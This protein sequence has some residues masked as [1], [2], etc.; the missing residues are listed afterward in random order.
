MNPFQS[1]LHLLSDPNITFILF[2]IGFYGLLFEV[3]HPNF[4]T[5]ILGGL[6]LILG[7]IGFGLAAV[8]RGRRVALLGLA[9]RPVLPGSERR[10]ATDCSRSAG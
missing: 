9:M 1:F 7:F 2:S 5:G 6:R 3:V 8:Q 10:R 4:V